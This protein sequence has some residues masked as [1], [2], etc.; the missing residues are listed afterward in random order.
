MGNYYV[1]KGSRIVTVTSDDGT[2]R[3]VYRPVYNNRIIETDGWY[4]GNEDVK[5]HPNGVKSISL[6][7]NTY[8]TISQIED[9]YLYNNIILAS[10]DSTTQN[11]PQYLKTGE[12]N[13][14]F[15]SISVEIQSLL[16]TLIDSEALTPFRTSYTYYPVMDARY[17]HVHWAYV[18]MKNNMNKS[19]RRIFYNTCIGKTLQEYKRFTTHTFPRIYK[20]P[21]DSGTWTHTEDETNLTDRDRV[22]KKMY[23]QWSRTDSS[24][25]YLILKAEEVLEKYGWPEDDLIKTS[26]VPVR[27]VFFTGAGMSEENGIYTYKSEEEGNL[28]YENP[29]DMIMTKSGWNSDPVFLNR[30]F[31]ELRASY[32][33]KNTM[34]LGYQI[35]NKFIN[36][37][38]GEGTNKHNTFDVKI[39]TQNIDDLH[40]KALC[41]YFFRYYNTSYEPPIYGISDSGFY[42]YM[43]FTNIGKSMTAKEFIDEHLIHLHGNLMI[44]CNED[45]VDNTNYHADL[46][47]WTKSVSEDDNT[48]TTTLAGVSKYKKVNGKYVQSGVVTIDTTESHKDCGLPTDAKVWT[49]FPKVKQTSNGN[50]KMRPWITLYHE[51][52]NRMTE[53]IE[54]VR[55][56]DIFVMVGTSLETFPAANLMTYVPSTTPI[57]YIDPNPNTEMIE[58]L[59]MTSRTEIVKTYAPN[60]LSHVLDVYLMGLKI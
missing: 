21:W 46:S 17:P 25:N 37:T 32:I 15:K 35:I 60:G 22:K 6:T 56:C 20:Q 45:D 4:D 39:I 27:I 47:Y 59:K 30:F 36:D 18:A 48:T 29:I 2:T 11:V 50:A 1:P 3:Q 34:H 40:D 14:K 52:V 54:L 12:L 41:D 26:E 58:K 49:Y 10:Y 28:W 55:S 42:K 7:Q 38:I 53:A 9:L 5:I 19:Q 33:N 31:N 8:L 16:F 13:E 51:T 43:K 23:K 44:M 24:A 57:I